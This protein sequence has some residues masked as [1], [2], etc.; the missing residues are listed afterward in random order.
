MIHFDKTVEKKDFELIKE[1]RYEAILN[2]EWR[3][4]FDGETI[5]NCSY[6]IRKDVEQESKGRIVF[7]KIKKDKNGVYHTGK[8][9]AI[10]A[11]IPN[12]RQDFETYDDLVQYMNDKLINIEV[13]IIKANPDYPNSRDKNGIKYYTSLPSQFPEL[14]EEN[15]S[16]STDNSS[17]NLPEV[18]E[19]DLPF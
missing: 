15:V 1:G 2:A 3:K 9:N 4:D 17:N 19:E 14:K 18:N 13:T 16:F 12:S 11:S 8:I 10:L 7:D 6:K 5:I